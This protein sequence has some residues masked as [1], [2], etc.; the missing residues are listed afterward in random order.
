MDFSTING[1]FREKS[2]V[3]I[4]FFHHNRLEETGGKA[5]WME[6]PNEREGRIGGKTE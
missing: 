4:G 6:R 1:F 3:R 2:T 5:E